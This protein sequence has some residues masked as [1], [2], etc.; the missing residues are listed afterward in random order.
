MKKARVNA[1]ARIGAQ[2]KRA[3]SRLAEHHTRP[4]TPVQY[5]PDLSPISKGGI[6]GLGGTGSRMAH[7]LAT[8]R[9]SKGAK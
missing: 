8:R 5:L 1:S 4:G 7:F 9:G 3:T 6:V 2:V